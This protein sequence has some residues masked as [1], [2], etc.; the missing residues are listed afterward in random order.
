M[1]AGLVELRRLGRTLK[2]RV[3]DVLAYFDRPG[4]ERSEEGIERQAGTSS[5]ISTGIPEPHPLHRL[6]LARD[7]RIQAPI[8][9]L[10]TKGRQS[11]EALV[12]LNLRP[13]IDTAAPTPLAVTKF[14]C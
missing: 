7:G 3:V 13:V 4:V 5:W 2:K 1:P 12:L 10:N 14:I 8:T 11:H 6:D 9:L